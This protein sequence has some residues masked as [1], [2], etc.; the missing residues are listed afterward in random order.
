MTWGLVCPIVC[1]KG[2][3]LGSCQLLGRGHGR[4]TW[5]GRTRECSRM[6]VLP[7]VGT[8]A[9]HQASVERVLTETRAGLEVTLDNSWSSAAPAPFGVQRT[10]T[11]RVYIILGPGGLRTHIRHKLLNFT[12]NS[13]PRAQVPKPRGG[14]HSE[15]WN[16]SGVQSPGE[17]RF[18]SKLG[19]KFCR[20]WGEPRS[21]SLPHTCHHLEPREETALTSSLELSV[22]GA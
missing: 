3:G 5:S 19:G 13:R 12:Y 20:C 15:F 4:S 14:Q 21:Q 22:Q 17:P 8:D 2:G 18:L 7:G 11:T 16:K 6:G 10:W 9:S 1:L